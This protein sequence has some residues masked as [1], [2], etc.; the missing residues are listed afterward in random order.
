MSPNTIPVSPS[1]IM[2]ASLAYFSPEFQLFALI[3][4]LHSNSTLLIHP[5]YPSSSYSNRTTLNSLPPEVLLIIQS[6]LLPALISHLS[7]LS[8]CALASYESSI[9]SLLCADC[10]KYNKDV[11]GSTFWNWPHF[12]GPCYCASVETSC[13][14]PLDG[15][16][17][18]NLDI[19][20]F[21]NPHHWL[22]AHLSE[23]ANNIIVAR[24]K[25]RTWTS[26]KKEVIWDL[27]ADVLRGFECA[28]VNEDGTPFLR[29]TTFDGRNVSI[30]P[31]CDEEVED[32]KDRKTIIMR[33]VWRELGLRYEYKGVRGGR[34]ED[35]RP[36]KARVAGMSLYY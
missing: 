35:Q 25:V 29:S 18:T 9:L 1:T 33:R 12:S 14:T 11:Y 2:H 13:G 32:I 20:Q 27:V 24:P 16:E 4:R 21:R 3:I 17:I 34:E 15:R 31:A 23:R 22:E 36:F 28:I 8:D 7:T 10:Q 6:H 26:E 19:N 5:T 30:V